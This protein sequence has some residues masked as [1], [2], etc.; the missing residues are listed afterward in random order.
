M[1][2]A[3]DVV[4]A[5]SLGVLS[6]ARSL[7]P[8]LSEA[9]Q[10][11]VG[12]LDANAADLIKL[13]VKEL[14]RRIGV[15]EAT[16]IRCCQAL[17]YRG[18]RDFRLALA[19]ETLSPHRV[20]HEAVHPTDDAVAIVEKVLRSDIQALADTIATLDPAALEQAAQAL[21]RAARIEV[22]A[23]GSSVPIALD[24]YYRLLRIG[25]PVT[26]VSD[27]HLQATS[28]AQL[29]AGSV[30][31]AISHTGRTRETHRTLQLARQAGATTIL[32]SSYRNTP[33]G[34]LADIVL[35]TASPESALRPEA[36]ASR[37]TH[38]ALVDALSVLLAT[39]RA[40]AALAALVRD[41]AIIAEREIS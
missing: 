33:I 28:A 36:G 35:V 21:D 17:G 15:S 29:P 12:A 6:R 19:A 32:L 7:Y 26:V 18:L 3:S 24:A 30:A 2:T 41:D 25:L 4:L 8:S 31:F 16:V 39:R 27:S 10:R 14:A 34:E 1:S 5:P 38:L 13:P 23:N 20:I 9:E 11:V 37:V 40:D 22:Y